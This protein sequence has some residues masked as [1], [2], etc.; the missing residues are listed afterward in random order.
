MVK[1]FGI[2]NPNVAFTP[3]GYL[4]VALMKTGAKYFI[5]SNPEAV[6]LE[7]GD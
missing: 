5:N 3:T 1:I 7:M 6:V 4:K 2:T